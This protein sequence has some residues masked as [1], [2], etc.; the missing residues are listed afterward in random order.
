MSRELADIRKTEGLYPGKTSTL[1]EVTFGIQQGT[2]PSSALFTVF[3]NDLDT[4]T[5]KLKLELFIT[6][7][8]DDTK[9]Q[10]DI[11]RKGRRM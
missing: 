3:F 10:K 2:V 6:K 7:S 1:G 9:E 5:E 11:N 8:A 4:E